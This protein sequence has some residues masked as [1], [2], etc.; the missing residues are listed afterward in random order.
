[1][2]RLAGGRHEGRF[3]AHVQD[4]VDVAEVGPALLDRAERFLT[5]TGGLLVGWFVLSIVVA[6]C[7]SWSMRAGR[8]A[9]LPGRGGG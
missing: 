1:M 8:A 2:A 5:L 4:D 9:P 7:W 6:S 3:A